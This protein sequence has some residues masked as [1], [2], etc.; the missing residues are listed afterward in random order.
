MSE[1]NPS[2]FLSSLSQVVNDLVFSGSS[3]QC[4]HAHNIHVGHPVHIFTFNT[5]LMEPFSVV[6]YVGMIGKH[7]NICTCFIFQTGELVRVYKGHSH[8]VTVVVV[9]GKVMVT[10]C[11]DKLVRVYDLQVRI[12]SSYHPVCSVVRLMSRFYKRKS[13]SRCSLT[14]SWPAAGLRWTQ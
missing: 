5:N 1:F 8:A 14:V 11:L 9:L 4:V 2:L 3:D 6:S 12:L 13:E 7:I 10:A